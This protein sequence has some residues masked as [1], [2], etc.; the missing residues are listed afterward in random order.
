MGMGVRL[1]GLANLFNRTITARVPKNNLE[2]INLNVDDKN[3]EA[4][5]A[6]Q[7]RYLNSNDTHKD[8]IYFPIG[9]TVAVNWEDGEP[10]PHVVIAQGNNTDHNGWG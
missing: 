2:P 9:F 10:W 6:W 4:L 8:S 7:D 1:P 5:K 3:C